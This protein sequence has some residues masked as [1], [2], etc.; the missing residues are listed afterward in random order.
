MIS[1]AEINSLNRQLWA[2]WQFNPDFLGSDSRLADVPAH[3]AAQLAPDVVVPVG[4]SRDRADGDASA[5]APTDYVAQH[6]ITLKLKRLG[7]RDDQLDA[8]HFHRPDLGDAFDSWRFVGPGYLPVSTIS[9]LKAYCALKW[10]ILD[11]PPRSRHRDDAWLLVA[12]TE[13]AP[14]V[15]IGLRTK[16][17][18]KA[19]A[20]KPRGRTEDGS[21]I[22]EIVG[23]LVRSPESRDASAKE[24]WLRFFAALEERELVPEEVE[25]PR[26]CGKTAY[27]YNGP[28]GRKGIAFG[29]FAT[30]VSE[31]RSKKSR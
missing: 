9:L 8:L 26:D 31:F 14:L 24:L 25:A 1:C 30:I 27:R 6:P 5:T 17:A 23:A 13:A 22:R 15:E 29:R 16:A 12:Q 11:N 21:A 2:L 18:Q 7:I 20:R 10:L 4:S 19:R 28:R 3:E